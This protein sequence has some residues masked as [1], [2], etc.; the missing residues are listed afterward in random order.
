MSNQWS[1]NLRKRMESHQETSP[2]GLW[3]DI[4]Q[5]IKE[6]SLI[7]REPKRNIALLWGK[8]IGAIA[9]VVLV[10][11]LIGDS[12]MIENSQKSQIIT[13]KKQ[14]PHEHKNNLSTDQDNG[15]E[16]I[17]GNSSNRIISQTKKNTAI[18]IPKKTLY[19][20][21]E[22]GLVAKVEEEKHKAEPER[23]DCKSESN[24]E[25]KTCNNKP[26]SKRRDQDNNKE[27]DLNTY[28]P[29]IEQKNKYTKW[30]ASV[31]ASN[32]SSNSA[33][34]NEGY[35]HFVS[36][37]V[38]PEGSCED[39]IGGEDPQ[40]NIFVQNK[41]REVYT[42]IKHRQPIIIGVTA[43]YNID[44]KWSLT[45]G[46]TYTVLSSQLRSGSDNYYY[47]SEQTLHN[48]G[49]PLSINYNVWKSKKISIYL[50]A[51]GIVEKNVSGKLTTDY[52]LDDQLKFIQKDKISVE[53]LQ[54]SV[55]TS[56]G[57]QYNLSPKIGL[58]AE[59]GASYYFK[60]GSEIKTIYKEKP[61]NLSLRFGLRFSLN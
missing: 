6:K 46:L 21:D 33:K 10:M 55:N 17:T 49:I 15:N 40:S 41:Y 7:V 19:T 45:S 18:S 16:F 42:D 4:E 26:N 38:Q 13:Q 39:P 9:A 60:N 52:I 29:V 43:N 48:I 53:H 5:I 54:W 27:I 8:R 25:K 11:L 51:G 56:I 61:I 32:I 3:E 14:T 57:V 24:I 28:L 59:P 44:D 50:S 36:V 2:D 37:G 12:L 31:Y 30:L 22:S 35:G 20:K 34:K 1:D 47:T 23:E 58:Y